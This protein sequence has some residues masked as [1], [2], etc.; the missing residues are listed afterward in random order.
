MK[1]TKKINIF[2]A[3]LLIIALIV[4]PGCSPVLNISSYKPSFNANSVS[5]VENYD[6]L[7][8][9]YSFIYNLKS[10]KITKTELSRGNL[11][12]FA[13]YTK[14][15]IIYKAPEMLYRKTNPLVFFF[16]PD[17]DYFDGE[18]YYYKY[19]NQWYSDITYSE[20]FTIDFLG[21]PAY[22]FEDYSVSFNR[23]FKTDDGYILKVQG[24][25]DKNIFEISGV[26]DNNKIISYLLIE[27]ESTK[28]DGSIAKTALLIEYT[29]VNS[30][31]EFSLPKSLDLNNISY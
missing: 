15:E 3:V 24:K 23:L 25:A 12:G 14:E 30:D 8:L 19:N 6:A 16:A 10:A 27:F 11:F 1:K 4:L 17:F 21:I 18:N 9:Y 22:V 31:I 13:S 29:D 26:A 28:S 5:L 7:S 2:F 20:T